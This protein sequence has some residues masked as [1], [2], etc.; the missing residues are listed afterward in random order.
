MHVQTYTDTAFAIYLAEQPDVGQ[1]N[2]DMLHKL[3]LVLLL[4]TVGLLQCSCL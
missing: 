2:M 4:G 3:P 1:Q